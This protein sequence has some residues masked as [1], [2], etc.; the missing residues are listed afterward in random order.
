ML[1]VNPTRPEEDAKVVAARQR[2]MFIE[3]AARM[4][5]TPFLPS[6]P[7][8]ISDAVDSDLVGASYP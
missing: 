1:D 5:V 2:W 8:A 4:N 7:P 6:Q 3:W